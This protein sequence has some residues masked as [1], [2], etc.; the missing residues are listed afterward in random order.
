M[1]LN[2]LQTKEFQTKLYTGLIVVLLLIM[3]FYT[4]T[5]LTKYLSV[6]SETNVNVTLH[7]VLKDSDKNGEAELQKINTQDNTMYQTIQDQLNL[8]LPQTENH[9][10]LT[11]N[12]EKFETDNNRAKDPFNISSLQ[13]MPIKIQA[14]KDYD[15][16]P[17]SLTIH[18]SYTN[19]FKFLE[20]VGNSG[21]L[22]DGTRLLDIQSIVINFM[23]PKGTDN[24]ISG[25]D[26]INFNVS[27]N[28]YIRK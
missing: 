26:E 10:I 23:S 19:F 16:L 12:L 28:A 6:L 18:C 9:T 13:Y 27:I 25:Q 4:Y 21:T 14:S 7:N 15:I 20:Y 11:R 1:K 3:G 22:S 17:L 8:V 2:F 5:N 24:N